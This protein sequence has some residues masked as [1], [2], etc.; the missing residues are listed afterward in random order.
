MYEVL[1]IGSGAAGLS[2]AI[3]SARYN[4]STIVLG[5]DFGL[6]S[7]APIVENYPGIR[8]IQGLKLI[9]EMQEQAK[10][11]GAELILGEE[12][13]RIKR[14]KKYWLAET[15]SE[16][17]LGK[18]VIIATGSR[19]RKLGIKGEEEFV[20]RGVSYCAI[21]DAPF[22][23]GK[24]VSVVGGGNSALT[25]AILLSEF[26]EKVYLIH[27][28]TEFRAEPI[29]VDRLMNLKKEGRVEMK[30]GYIPREIVGT[31][32]VEYLHLKKVDEEGVEEK[33]KTE[34]IF[35][36]IGEVPNSE[37]AR[38]LGLKLDEEGYILVKEDMSTN[39]EG[40]FAAGDVTTG[41]NKLK[42][43]ITACAEGAIAATSA[44]RYIT[45]KY[46]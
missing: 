32:V 19:K 24:V 27:R 23:R 28:R 4:L 3:Y 25:S 6:A 11:L 2:A 17:Y 45:R 1:I 5:K 10:S 14:E 36:E 41:S 44:Y 12:V 40:V 38:N 26:A 34:G 22:Y 29:L 46:Q 37:L 20:G 18:A 16:K 21:C 15:H 31:D 35:V 8:E 39:L 43:I 9:Q 7:E 33:L 42:Q 30:L 13:T